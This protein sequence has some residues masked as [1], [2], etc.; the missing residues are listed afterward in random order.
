MAGAKQFGYDSMN[1]T[2][3]TEL[4]KT[5]CLV[6]FLWET[7]EDNKLGDWQSL[8]LCCEDTIRKLVA[9][10]SQRNAKPQSDSQFTEVHVQKLVKLIGALGN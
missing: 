9:A 10:A 4:S 8:K 7:L 5:I 6:G 2:P 1:M 3:G